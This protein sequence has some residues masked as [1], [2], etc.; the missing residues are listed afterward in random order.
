MAYHRRRR[1]QKNGE[2]T[3]ILFYSRAGVLTKTGFG[4]LR[5][6]V[7]SIKVVWQLC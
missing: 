4:R 2:Y 1:R 3:F 7:D 5:T 6:P